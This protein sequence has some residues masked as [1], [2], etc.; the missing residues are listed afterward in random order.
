MRIDRI[1]LWHVAVPLPAPFY[2]SW[3]PGFRQ[4]ENRFDLIRLRTSDGIEGWSAVPAMAKERRG[5]GQLL[6]SYVLGERADDIASIRQ[7]IRELGYLGHRAGGLVEPAC[8]DIIG[9]AR[10]CPVHEV[11]G[12]ARGG[13]VRLYAS[14]GEVKTG[15]ERVEEVRQRVAEGFDC[16]K[17]RVH[18]DTLAEDVAQLRAVREAFPD[19]KLGVDANMGWRVA[20]I[21]ECAKWDWQRAYEFCKEAEQLGFSWVEEPLPNDD[22]AGLARLRAATEVTIA[23]GELNN[24]GLPDFRHMVEVGCYGWY[25]PDA[26]M[27]GGISEA[28]A[29]VQLVRAGG[30]EFSPHTW[31]NGVG[32]AINLQ[33]YAAFP[34]RDHHLEFPL[35]P[36]GWLPEGRDGL[37]TEPWRA[38]RGALEIPTKPGLG[39]EIDPGQLRRFGTRFYT[40]TKARVAVSTVLDRGPRLAAYLGGVRTKRIEARA[41]EIEA[42]IRAG[43]D[44]VAEALAELA[45]AQPRSEP[46][47]AEA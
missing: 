23:G 6:G 28:W 4:E 45:P 11:L 9:K 2:P 30:A 3:I 29:I 20:A 31:T 21:A 36:P 41:S 10:G 13:S 24:Y 40:G 27:V 17:L 19:L 34:E 47:A 7:R 33:L 14:T 26:V 12:G 25:Q 16:V 44:P 5:W 32:F 15:A 1:D 22:Y 38:E 37:L 43:R 42:Q 18:A 35:N 8:W 39:F 46:A